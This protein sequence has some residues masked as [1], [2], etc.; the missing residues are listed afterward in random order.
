VPIEQ[1]VA[2]VNIDM[3]GRNWPDT[4]VAIGR[5]HSD[6]GTTLDRVAAAHPELRMAVIDDKWPQERFYFRSTTTTSRA[7]ACRS[8][9]SST[10]CTRTTTSLGRSGEDRRGE[11]E[12]HREDALLARARDRER[13]GEP[14][15][16]EASYKDIVASAR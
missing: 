4:I 10:A 15:W 11:G 7:R 6:L 2:D 3:I 16:N 1:I 12:P 5:E 13:T 9:S 14:K 8:S